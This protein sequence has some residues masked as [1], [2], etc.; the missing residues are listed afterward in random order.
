MQCYLTSVPIQMMI[1]ILPCSPFLLIF[2]LHEHFQL[3]DRYQQITQ[4][5]S[6]FPSFR[7]LDS[8][9]PIISAYLTYGQGINEEPQQPGIMVRYLTSSS[10]DNNP[11]SCRTLRACIAEFCSSFVRLSLV[12]GTRSVGGVKM[13][14]PCS[15]RFHE[16]SFDI[17]T[18]ST[19]CCR[20]CC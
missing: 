9:L 8:L 14:I 20:G 17:L 15:L 10:F 18:C 3:V 1:T 4:S 11:L 5:L 13:D 7:R 6:F 2:S 12:L 19:Q 16:W